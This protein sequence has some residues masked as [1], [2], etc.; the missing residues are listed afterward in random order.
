MNFLKFTIFLLLLATM[1]LNSFSQIHTKKI[2]PEN[3]SKVPLEYNVNTT[4]GGDDVYGSLKIQVIGDNLQIFRNIGT[5]NWDH[6]YYDW[7]EHPGRDIHL[8]IGGG[9]YYVNNSTDIYVD[10]VPS[11]SNL[12]YFEDYD[13]IPFDRIDITRIDDYNATAKFIKANV[14]EAFLTI[15]YPPESDYI[16]YTW[17]ITNIGTSTMNDIRFFEEGDTYSYGSDYGMGYWDGDRNTVGCQKMDN[18]ELV[19]VFLEALEVPYQH[20]SANYGFYDGVESHVMNNALTGEVIY[21]SHDN[22]IAL[23]WRKATLE[24][25]EAWEIH[26]I[27]K[28]SD[29]EIT[30]LIVTAPYNQEI[31]QG[32]T[33]YINFNVRN[34]SNETVT[35]IALSD[36]IDLAGW[37]SEIVNPTGTFTLLQ[38]EETEVTISV[39]CPIDAIPGDIA[40]TT[41]QATAN[42]VTADDKAYIEVLSIL[43]NF[44]QQPVNQD[45]CLENDAVT[46]IVS[47]NNGDAYQWQ[48]YTNVWTNIVNTGVFSGANNDTLHISD[49]TG[50]VGMEFRCFVANGYGDD[51]SDSATIILDYTAPVPDA[52]S[53]PDIT[54]QCEIESLIPP[55]ATDEC[56]GNI[57][58]T[59]D[60]TFPIT[61]DTTITWSFSDSKGNTSYLIQD[62]IIDDISAPVPD[63]TFLPNISESCSATVTTIPTA[64]DGC[65]GVVSGTTTD[66]LYYDTVGTYLITW[67]YEDYNGNV[68]SQDQ[69]VNVVDNSPVVVTKDTTFTITNREQVIT[70]TADDI[71]NGSSDDCGIDTMYLDKK[72]FSIE[73]EGENTVNLTVVDISG[74][75][76]V[77]SAIVTI[78][79]NADSIDYTILIPNFVSPDNDGKNDLWVIDGIE[80]LN[81]FTL[82]IFNNIG[83]VVY[84]SENYDNTWDATYKGQ[85]LPDGTYYYI[86]K[87]GENSYSGFVSVIK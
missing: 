3:G 53:L 2:K 59:T 66:A 71:D 8:Y 45:I 30:N 77:K 74:K 25:G 43:P 14:L 4:L 80:G 68:E 58:G 32:E 33:K 46:F 83:E 9:F 72:D 49:A 84:H 20:E 67:T 19:S 61:E 50:L 11:G 75:Q 55:T 26:T 10:G 85:A 57:V 35:G 65:N 18:G 48:K 73:N 82:D 39:T 24:E 78:F 6:Q 56:E 22:A 81:G 62:I 86:F 23:E 36:V 21:T 1:S 40:K 70:I 12:S 44:N 42:D 29:K 76:S 7:S 87:S 34:N 38:S 79:V 15:N 16:N 27:E 47:S 54:E 60:A 28:Y 17:K 13:G 51:Y 63:L 5:N 64:T 37:S 52:I 41:L 69:T 31:T